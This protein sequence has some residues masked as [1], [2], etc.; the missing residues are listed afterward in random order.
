MQMATRFDRL[1][2][3]DA[4]AARLG[5]YESR[6]SGSEVVRASS[7]EL[8]CYPRLGGWTRDDG[9]TDVDIAMEGCEI[10]DR[11]LGD[12]EPSEILK[13]RSYSLSAFGI[14][15][16]LHHLDLNDLLVLNGR[17]T[18]DLILEA[19]DARIHGQSPLLSRYWFLE[20]IRSLGH[21]KD[22]PVWRKM[23]PMNSTPTVREILR[24][25]EIFRTIPISQTK[26]PTRMRAVVDARFRSI[27]LLREVGM[28]SLNQIGFAIGGR[29]HTTVLNGLIQ[30]RSK[31]ARDIAV[32][33]ATRTLC[34]SADL[35]G[36]QRYIDTIMQDDA[37]KPKSNVIMP[38]GIAPREEPS[39]QVPFG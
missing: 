32:N 1:S 15:T 27:Y 37:G 3:L 25:V 2:R 33:S 4:L 20:H 21:V 5:G 31:M 23:K 9:K 13:S 7:I 36:M 19:A 28:M 12:H 10:L 26:S 16:L 30:H 29:D 39:A 11:L 35:L 14:A 34:N 24:I 22:S 6:D 17:K 18:E 38:P 8:A